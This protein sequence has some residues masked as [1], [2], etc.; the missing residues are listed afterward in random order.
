MNSQKK[1][2]KKREEP[3]GK[4]HSLAKG[5]SCIA[6]VSGDTDNSAECKE[7]SAGS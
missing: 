5:R 6:A 7:P 3:A 4:A 2:K 1:E